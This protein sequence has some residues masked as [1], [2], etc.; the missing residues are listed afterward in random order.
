MKKTIWAVK[1]NS[2]NGSTCGCCSMEFDEEK[3]FK[4]YDEAINFV[5]EQE[6]ENYCNRRVSKYHEFG[7][8]RWEPW[9]SCEYYIY[10]R[11]PQEEDVYIGD[12]KKDKNFVKRCEELGKKK[13]Q[14]REEENKQLKEKKEAKD[15]R[16][17][18]GVNKWIKN[19]PE[20]AKRIFERNKKNV[21]F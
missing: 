17:I 7:K 5:V 8:P 16:I 18:N 20:E 6:A 4:T 3:H 11:A 9:Y 21:K 12:L 19:N 1:Y 14:K 10:E 15:K 2:H 13:A